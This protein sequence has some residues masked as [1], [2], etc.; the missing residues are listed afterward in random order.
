VVGTPGRIID[1]LNR[2]SL[3]LDNITYMVL[4]KRMKCS[5]GFIEDMERIMSETNPD[6]KTLLFSATMLG[7]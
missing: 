5:T 4:E 1:H 2:R 3:R 6:K 7:A